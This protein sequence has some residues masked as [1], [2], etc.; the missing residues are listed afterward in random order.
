MDIN[1][2]PLPYR[3]VQCVCEELKAAEKAEAMPS[4]MDL[5]RA[6]VVA[7]ALPIPE[8]VGASQ[9]SVK[10]PICRGIVGCR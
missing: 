6:A 4:D 8:A 10:M 2:I 7:K 3:R 9:R 1:G 5:C